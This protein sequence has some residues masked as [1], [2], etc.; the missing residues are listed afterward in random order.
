VVGLPLSDQQ[1]DEDTSVGA[2][3]DTG[4]MDHL[5][6]HAGRKGSQSVFSFKHDNSG[7][8]MFSSSGALQDEDHG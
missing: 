1:E 3:M 6:H 7:D 8:L 4:P 5:A 2:I